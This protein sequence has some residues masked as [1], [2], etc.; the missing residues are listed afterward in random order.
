MAMTTMKFGFLAPPLCALVLAQQVMPRWA[1]NVPTAGT[2][3]RPM[4]LFAWNKSP[5]P[6]AQVLPSHAD[7]IWKYDHDIE[8]DVIIQQWMHDCLFAPVYPPL[9]VAVP[10]QKSNASGR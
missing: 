3:P 2:A 8:P 1:R 4:P 5:D 7:D 10:I 9:E 6:S